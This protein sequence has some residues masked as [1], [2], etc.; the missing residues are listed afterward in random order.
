MSWLAKRHNVRRSNFAAMLNDSSWT[1]QISWMIENELAAFSAY[2]LRDLKRLR[3]H[4]IR[5]IVSLTED[6][7]PELVGVSQFK[8]LHL[9]IVD[10]SPPDNEQIVRF[11]DFVDRMIGEGRA[12]GV[13]CLAGL[14]RTGT[15]IACYL[16][17]RGLSAVEAIDHV[18]R[19]R[20]GSIQTDEQERAIYRWEM[21]RSGKWEIGRF[22]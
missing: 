18:R 8:L 6:L 2:V 21:A 17:T 1:M 22:L 12:V 10:M 13:H 5:A 16:V 3:A 7:P 19:I 14:G 11:V 15:M 20:P 4:G 9:P